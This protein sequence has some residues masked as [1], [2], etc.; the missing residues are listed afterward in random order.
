[1][2][3]A[4]MNVPSSFVHI[5]GIDTDAGSD[6]EGG[7]FGR[8]AV[9]FRHFVVPTGISVVFR[10]IVVVR[11]IHRGLLRVGTIPFVTFPIVLTYGGIPHIIFIA[12][13]VR[14]L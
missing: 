10:I 11:N 14:Y 13:V 1:M 4:F 3:V 2:R 9:C 7:G 5:G 8:V 6:V 12:G